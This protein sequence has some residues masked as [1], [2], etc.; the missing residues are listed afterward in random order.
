M[1]RFFRKLAVFFKKRWVWTL[2][3][4]LFL[5]LLVW[6]LFPYFGFGES[7]PWESSTSRLVT[8]CIIFLLWGLLLVFLNWR[9]TAKQKKKLTS[10]QV[11]EKL[12][13]EEKIYE[14]R[15]A[16]TSLYKKAMQTLKKSSI[17]KGR[18]QSWK[19]DLP[20]YLLI[21]P[22]SSGKTSILDFS[23]LNFPLNQIEQRL[24]KNIEGTR[25]CEWYFAE[26]G[27][28]VDT[29]GRYFS[30][31]NSEVDNA[32]WLTL[33]NLLR[34]RKRSR[35]L[36][37]V[38]VN[39]PVDDLLS[40]DEVHLERIARQTRARLHDIQQRL[41]TECPVYILFSK[42]DHIVGFNEFFDNI[43]QE[44]SAQVLGVTFTKEQKVVSA[45]LTRFEFERLLERLNKQVVNNLHQER[46]IQRRGKIL[47]FPY[48]FNLIAEQL[49]LFIELATTG[50]RY[51]EASHLRGFYFMSAPHVTEH[52]DEHTVRIGRNLGLSSKALPVYRQGKPR[53]L[54][55]LFTSVIF[56]ESELATLDE[57]E[58]KRLSW[59]Q[60]SLYIG[61]VA[62][63][64]G[65]GLL[66][67]YSF[68]A[69]NNYLKQTNELGVMLTKQHTELIP[70]GDLSQLESVLNTSYDAYK[71]FPTD[72]DLS[73]THQLGLYQGEKTT[74]TVLATYHDELLKQMLPAVARQ[75]ETQIR[76]NFTNR[77]KLLN[78]LRA[79]LMLNYEQH[80]DKEYLAATMT[81]YWAN[82]YPNNTELQDDLEG[83]FDRLLALDF[84]Y[85]LND[86]LV[87]QAR[88]I[89]S[90]EPLANL[91][92]NAMKQDAKILPDYVLSQ[93]LGSQGYLI[94]GADNK[95][96]GFFTKSG[97]NQYF[98]SKKALDFITKTLK[99]NWV[100]GSAD[101]LS[102][103][104]LQKILV[105]VEQL[106][107]IDYTDQWSNTIGGLKV[108]NVNS[109]P[110]SDSQLTG[111]T[112]ANS[113]FLLLLGEIKEHTKL[114]GIVPEPD[115]DDKE[116]IA[117]KTGAINTNSSV[118]Q[119][120]K[121][122]TKKAAIKGVNAG[123]DGAKKLAA[124]AVPEQGKKRM[125]QM[126][127]PYHRLLLD[128]GSPS[129]DYAAA[130]QALNDL[131]QKV[132]MLS[133][134]SA[135][136]Q[137]ALAWAKDR[138]EG[139]QDALSAV[140][141]AVKRLPAPFDK[142]YTQIAD[143]NWRIILASSYNYINQAY[144][145]NVY[146]YYNSSIR[147][148]YPFNGKANTDVAMSD[149]VRFFKVG[150]IMDSFYESNLKPFVSTNGS[151]YQVKTIDGRGLPISSASL[152][153]FRVV[154]VIQ[155]GLFS[156][157]PEH[158]TVSFK[159]EPHFLEVTLSRVI[160]QIGDQKIEY[161]HGPILS[162]RFTWPTENADTSVVSE[163]FEDLSGNRTLYQTEP[164]AW[165][166]FRFI[167]QMEIS[168][169]SG[170]DVMILKTNV[171]G[172]YANYLLSTQRSPNPFDVKIYRAF[173]L[174]DNL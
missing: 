62:T 69:N 76:S 152:A 93:H 2:C 59:K 54:Y 144:K 84:I 103:A 161:R 53:F 8:I 85:P 108:A 19:H 24:T 87:A 155:G 38:L 128:D 111:L 15:Q 141:N 156:E 67:G 90:N 120:A 94:K 82:I 70:K 173:A 140:Q 97:Y 100:L 168:Y 61:S 23:G 114:P 169:A 157:N 89:L 143:D 27:V 9:E 3:I 147:G 171:D 127:T 134:D 154:R 129:S 78:S 167:D 123:I 77:E 136:E 33:L 106:Y 92:Y 83:H 162:N 124:A 29:S 126:F 110:E 125:V 165:S 55:Q 48:Q 159:L 158:P 105:Q 145:A 101:T 52:L 65:V 21:G 45:D 150:G 71:V 137:A 99:D 34:R 146:T 164:G 28:V 166:L 116:V 51:Q 95:I 130:S 30:Q 81:D 31:E 4:A 160:L 73:I 12:I 104:E 133:R 22:E 122:A 115:E 139:Q 50:N 47:D 75:L 66:W 88:R 43:S 72:K 63:L 121:Q 16:V 17:Y 149:F 42:A 18:S 1:K 64:A 56:P 14:E 35:P 13:V 163:K 98:L 60:R 118:K 107:F 57:T 5:A 36:N 80:R 39:V 170:R 96:A 117:D 142:W 79:Y 112:A 172:K 26:N 49:C 138:M 86:E 40:H 113:P 41:G 68:S 148:R 174:R 6:F 131:N 37:G 102:P 91:V 20:W 109:F 7:K 10:D 25:Y 74:P 153:Q 135:P 11:Q 151:Y 44:E 132:S 32:G 119:M 58:R 46:D